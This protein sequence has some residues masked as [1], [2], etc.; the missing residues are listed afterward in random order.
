MS[1]SLQFF[2]ILLIAGMML[3]GA[4]IFVPGGILGIIGGAALVLAIIAGFAAFGLETGAYITL[5]IMVLLTVV[6]TVWIKFFPRSRLGRQM[7][8][9]SD[10]KTSKGTQNGLADLVG[11]EGVALSTLRPSGFA[12]IDGRRVDVVTQGESLARGDKLV[13]V[14]VGSN[15]VVVCRKDSEKDPSPNA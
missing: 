3:I 4:E 1:L 8:A 5:G 13:V 12:T 11:K 10:L 9:S 6:I 15:R 2:L 14:D 7:T